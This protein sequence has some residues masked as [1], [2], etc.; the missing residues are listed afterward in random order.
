MS[1]RTPPLEDA[2]TQAE[3]ELTVLR[4]RTDVPDEVR[5]E[6]EQRV[7]PRLH[8]LRDVRD[9]LKPLPIEQ[10]S[11]YCAMFLDSDSRHKLLA[12]WMKHVEVPLHL[13]VKIH[14]MTIKFEPQGMDCLFCDMDEQKTIKVI[15][16]AADERGQAVLVDIGDN[17]IC[18]NDHPHVTMAVAE[19]TSAAYSNALLARGH[20]PIDGPTLTG[21]ADFAR[22]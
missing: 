19:G 14:H 17:L 15:G 22:D 18:Y 16:W 5:Y 7:G 3:L 10:T 11:F 6:R 4:S 1:N 20:T 21:W 2:I 9:M 8:K 13:D 12:W